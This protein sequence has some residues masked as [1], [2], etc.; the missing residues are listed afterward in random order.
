MN[1]KDLTAAALL[2]LV[3]VPCLPTS[4]AFAQEEPDETSSVELP[5]EEDEEPEGDEEEKALEITGS[6]ASEVHTFNNLDMLPLDESSD[7]SIIE[8]DDRNTFGFTSATFGVDYEIIDDLEVEFAAGHAGMWGSD[9]LGALSYRPV[10]D[11]PDR[12]AHWLWIYE[13]GIEWDAV[14]SDVLGVQLEVGRHEFEIGGQNEDEFFFEDVHDGATL[15]V[16]AKKIGALRLTAGFM[17]SNSR[18]ANTNF[19]QY[20]A[21]SGNVQGFRGDTNTYRL[22]GVYEN[23]EILEGLDVRAFGFYGD[24]GASTSETGTGADRSFGG[25]LGNFSD[26]DYIWMVGGRAGYTFTTDAIEVGGFGEFAHSGGIDRKD[27]QIGLFDVANDGNAYGLG[28]H[29]EFD[30]GAAVLNARLRGFRADGGQYARSNGVQFNHGFTSF[31]GDEVGGLN[32]DRYAG[33][34]PSAYLS[35]DGIDD[36]PNELDRKSGTQ[37]VSGTLGAQI[38]EKFGAQLS[39]WYLMDTSNSEFDQANLDAIA[40]DLPFGY[41][42]AGLEAQ[43]RFGKPLGTELDLSL[44]FTPNKHLVFYGRGGV[45]LPSSFY[46]IPIERTAAANGDDTALGAENPATFWAAAFGTSVRF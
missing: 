3:C 11:E 10:P 41:T 12:A 13:L 26:S 4:E 2:G 34:H 32:M 38:A 5:D 37:F 8:T 28:I 16:D 46:E 6:L 25:A 1:A 24:I 40:G 39:A 43:E 27:T 31:K 36:N 20:V 30:L 29:S 15:T 7:Q 14:E 45:F 22:G 17:G 21:N 44:N 23:T 35:R 9:Q 33:W 19:V 18:P 42:Q